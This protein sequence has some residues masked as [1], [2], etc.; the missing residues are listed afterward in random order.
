MFTKVDIFSH[1]LTQRY[2]EKYAEINPRIKNRV[3]FYTPPVVNLDIREKLMHRYP[4]VLQVITMANIP[5]E[6]WA[7][8]HSVEL[9]RVGNEELSELVLK[10]PDL[11]FGAVAVLPLNDIDASLVE[12]DYAINTLHLAGIQVQTR[13]GAEW[14]ASPKYRPIIARMAELNKPIWIHPDNN[15]QLD[16]DIGIF[17]WPFETSHCMLRLVESGVFNEFPNV[18]FIVHHAGAMI[19]FFKERV[20]YVMSLVPQPFHNIHEHFKKFYVDTAIYG[21]TDGLMCAYNYYGAE[22]M[23]FGT[24]APLGPRWGMVEDTVLSIERM[25]ISQED[26]EKILKYNAVELFKDVV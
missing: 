24:D 22:H 20:K 14:L 21:N 9:A 25:T 2:T 18:K 13:I 7:P 12:I 6:K 15:D 16:N 26:K 1:I 4:D 23:F 19:P 3:E 5:L 17:S 8:E 10:R 11:F